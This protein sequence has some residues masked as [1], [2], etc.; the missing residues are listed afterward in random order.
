[1]W[2]PALKCIH[3]AASGI[4]VDLN[5]LSD[6]EE[7]AGLITNLLIQSIS[8]IYSQCQTAGEG[9]EWMRKVPCVMHAEIICF[10]W[11][12]SHCLVD[13]IVSDYV[14]LRMQT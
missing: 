10:L 13:M 3:T 7:L 14:F 4:K 12:Q 6:I 9:D 11:K 2:V 1:M 8:D 5:C